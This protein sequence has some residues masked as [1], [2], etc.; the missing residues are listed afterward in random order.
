MSGVW[1]LFYYDTFFVLF[2]TDF[3]IHFDDGL[4]CFIGDLFIISKLIDEE[5]NNY[6]VHFG[7]FDFGPENIFIHFES[8]GH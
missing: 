1:V 6:F 8:L 5:I 2:E 7:G 4:D 3:C